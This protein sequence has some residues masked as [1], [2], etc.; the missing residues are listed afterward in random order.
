MQKMK[1]VL[2]DWQGCCHHCGRG[3]S[4]CG[5]LDDRGFCRFC[6]GKGYDKLY[7]KEEEL[8]LNR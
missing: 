1:D 7:Y 3:T 2:G 8:S 6:K 4:V 5:E